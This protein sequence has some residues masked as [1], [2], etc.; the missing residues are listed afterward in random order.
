MKDRKVK[1]VLSRGRFQWE[2]PG[3]HKKMVKE[4]NDGGNILYSCMKIE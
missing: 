4:G 1:Q 3:G 2:A